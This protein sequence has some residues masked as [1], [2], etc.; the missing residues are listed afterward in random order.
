VSR[1][2]SIT[3]APPEVVTR[4]VPKR[5]QAWIERA[6]SADHKTVGELYIA[7]ALVALAAAATEFA[8][9]RVQLIIPEQQL[10]QPEIFNRLMSSSA[11]T[12]L[13]LF[14]IPL[15][16]GLISYVVPLQIGARG[17]AFPRL[18]QLS[19]WLYAA[20]AF[21]LYASF[22]YSAPESGVLG[23]PPLADTTFTNTHGTDAW[24]AAMALALAGFTCFAINMIVTLRRMRAPG[25]AWR[26][27]PPFAWSGAVISWVLVVIGPVMIA[28]LTMLMIDRNFNGIFFDSEQGG[29]PLLYEHLAYIF[30][31]G[32][33]LTVLIFAAGVISEVLP[34]FAR[35]PL[36]SHR[37]V[38]ASIAAIAPLGLLA[39]MQNM[40]TAPLASAWTIGAMALAVALVIPIGILLY[41]WIATVWGGTVRLRA[42]IWYALVAIST[43]VCGLTA[44]LA[45]SVIPVG[46]AL[47]NTTAS[48]GATLYVL[49]GGGVMGGFAAL[50]Y[51]FPKL[52]GRVLGEGI[53]K[54]ALGLMFI[55]IHLYVVPMFLAGLQGQAMDVFKYFSD[56]GVD[57]YNLAASIGAFI[58]VIGILLELG[59]A[60][61]SW[62]HG[63]S[64][65]GHDPWEAATLEWFAESP[66]PPHNFDAVPDVRS[67]EPLYD[68]RAAVRARTERFEPPQP[69]EPPAAAAEE[70]AQTPEP[71]A[72]RTASEAGQ[73]E[74]DGGESTPVA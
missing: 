40:Y 15:G 58:L 44:E 8:L 30:F 36:F 37:A 46:W 29:A 5:R 2:P 38:L 54:A 69:L 56:Q 16:L 57:G 47:D 32:C 18:N 55:G 9:M 19:Y 53:G 20:G 65:R 33:Y 68:I 43:I 12:F 59:N 24:I 61:H 31:T 45:Y 63:L 7:T 51:W 60:A 13:V 39:W 50:H 1:L 27:M 22:L 17:V 26:R 71:E 21:T 62:H 49:V 4:G 25:V 41:S 64:A 67:P 70:E 72:S 3:Q 73:G 52:S 74:T 11:T 10:I 42:A 28:A 23:L 48:Q 66:P 6:T 34:T 14:A 35:K